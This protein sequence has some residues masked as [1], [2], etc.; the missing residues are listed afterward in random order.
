MNPGDIRVAIAALG[1]ISSLTMGIA[2][3]YWDAVAS[4]CAQQLS[5]PMRR[6]TLPL[7]PRL[8]HQAS[9][10]VGIFSDFTLA[11][12]QLLERLPT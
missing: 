10:I 3:G 7:P 5:T 1:P 6:S 2:M 11:V 8:L 9:Y 4:T 12:I